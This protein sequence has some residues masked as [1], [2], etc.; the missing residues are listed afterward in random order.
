MLEA[1]ATLSVRV[2]F[3]TVQPFDHGLDRHADLLEIREEL[4]EAFRDFNS[5]P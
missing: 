5:R 2:A 1:S 4:V 3:G